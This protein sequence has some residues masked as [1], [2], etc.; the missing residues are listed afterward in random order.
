M[1][2]VRAHHSIFIVKKQCKM[3]EFGRRHIPGYK[4]EYGYGYYEFTKDEF[5]KPHKKVILVRQVGLHN[6]V[7]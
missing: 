4:P 1:D 2:R 6:N 7:M 5:F 3:E